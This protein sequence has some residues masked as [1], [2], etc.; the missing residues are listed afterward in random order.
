M[1]NI[2]AFIALVSLVS[3]AS[4]MVNNEMASLGIPEAHKAEILKHYDTFNDMMAKARVSAGMDAFG[5]MVSLSNSGGVVDQQVQ[6]IF[7]KCVSEF[8]DNCTKAKP[9]AGFWEKGV[10]AYLAL[11][12]YETHLEDPDMC[13]KQAKN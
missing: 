4:T 2:F 13:P 6:Q 5:S 1:K 8:G 12:K 7:C 9:Q 10:G 11:K 3:C